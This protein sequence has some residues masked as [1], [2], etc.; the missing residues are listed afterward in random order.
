[1]QHSQSSFE[2]LYLAYAKAM[3]ASLQ[4]RI[5]KQSPAPVTIFVTNFKSGGYR[6]L[7]EQD[8]QLD[9]YLPLRNE[10]DYPATEAGECA[11]EAFKK[12]IIHVSLS[13]AQGRSIPSPTF[14]QV[15]PYVQ[16]QLSFPL[17]DLLRRKRSHRC[18]TR[19]IAA[20]IRR[21]LEYWSKARISRLYFLPIGAL[22][23][24][25]EKIKLKGVGVIK[26]LG[27]STKNAYW[28][29]G[30]RNWHHLS[31]DRFAEC[32]YAL[33]FDPTREVNQ[34][35]QNELGAT[36]ITALRLTKAGKVGGPG[37]CHTALGTSYVG[38]GFSPID[39]ADTYSVFGHRDD[40]FKLTPM[41][42]ASFRRL[43]HDLTS[44]KGKIWKAM[45][46]PLGRFNRTYMRHSYE[47]IIIDLTLCLES[48]LLADQ[49]KMELRYRLGL[50]GAKL[51]GSR[52][53]VV[54]PQAFL[55][56]LYDVRSGIVHGGK[57]LVDLRKTW[58]K[59][60]ADQT[61]FLADAEQI[62]RAILCKLITLMKT[63]G[64]LKDVVQSVEREIAISVAR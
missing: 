6:D 58:N 59:V 45:R 48:T 9:R 49:D 32:Q 30:A 10:K 16:S 51:L 27:D 46:I 4:S 15:L 35:E 42:T 41:Q 54:A 21:Y 18:T 2:R 13:D 61:T 11:L 26:M 29:N 64:S 24:P 53:P 60:A 52:H 28:R 50:R 7:L 22:R 12:K 8:P 14:E 33:F 34:T 44:D 39:D 36:V 5:E 57:S 43:F 47:D 55:Q 40:P 62:V 3:L 1:M 25:F 23:I 19:E 38:A 20:T 63:D 37:V 31:I 56:V 17:I